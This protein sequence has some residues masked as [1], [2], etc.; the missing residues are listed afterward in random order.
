M[1]TL[2]ITGS[3]DN[4]VTSTAT[5]TRQPS[6][7]VQ[8]KADALV[9][10]NAAWCRLRNRQTGK[11]VAYAVPSQS[12]PNLFYRTNGVRCE[13]RGF[14]RHGY[15]AHQLAAATYVAIKRPA[16]KEVA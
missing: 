1:Q 11:C 7:A 16:R 9:L 5:R 13:C 15:C 2:S 12:V 8:A 14:E 3:E 4:P 10:N 6:A